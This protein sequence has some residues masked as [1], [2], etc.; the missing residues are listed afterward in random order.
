MGGGGLMGYGE[1]R[2][3]EGDTLKSALTLTGHTLWQSYGLAKTAVPPPAAF[4]W[5]AQRF[6]S[7]QLLPLDCYPNMACSNSMQAPRPPVRFPQPRASSA[8]VLPEIPAQTTCF[9]ESSSPSTLP[10]SFYAGV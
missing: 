2:C 4:P 7:L 8:C 3:S 10:S 6:S 9:L 1:R 5:D